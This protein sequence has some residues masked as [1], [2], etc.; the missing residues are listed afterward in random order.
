MTIWSWT[1]EISMSIHPSMIM[2]W[3]SRRITYTNSTT[4]TA[5]TSKQGLQVH[6]NVGE[7]RTAPLIVTGSIVTIRYRPTQNTKCSVMEEAQPQIN[8]TQTMI[9]Q[10]TH[11]MA[12]SIG[13]KVL[14]RLD[15]LDIP[16][17]PRREQKRRDKK[18]DL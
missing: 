1:W 5:K 3:M 9:S 14:T 18:S 7:L 15:R 11:R 8:S 4:T 12:Q 17:A 2:M 16:L 6:H 13:R 10:T